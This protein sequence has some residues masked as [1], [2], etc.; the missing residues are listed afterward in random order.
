MTVL[1]AIIMGL[2]Q[3]LTEFL[4]VSSSAHLVFAD[5]FLHLH[6]DQAD[7]V[8]FDVLLHLGT[9]L[10]VL[11]YFRRDVLAL[12]RGAGQLLARP[13]QAW[14]ENPHAR[15][16]ALLVL[17]TIPAAL[18]GVL[19]KDFFSAA[20]QNV[21]GTAT[22]LLV[23][24]AMLFWITSRPV[25]GR[26]LDTANWK[27]ALLVG[28]FQAVAILPGVSRSGSTI[29]GGLVRGLDRDAA[30]RF[31]F[32]LSIPIILAGGLFDLKDTLKTGYHLPS[33]ALLAGFLTAAISGYIA[34]VLLMN[35][36]RRGRLNRFGYYC[37]AA[38]LLMLGYWTLLVPQIDAGKAAGLINQHTFSVNADGVL[39]P[40][41]MGQ[42]VQ[43]TLPVQAG[44][45]PLHDAYA[46]LP[47]VDGH[48]PQRISL[49]PIYTG[50]KGIVLL[51]SERYLLRPL[52][53]ESPTG[54][55]NIRNIWVVVRNRWGIQ[56]EVQLQLLIVPV[57]PQ[58]GTA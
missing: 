19:L 22:L 12:L 28:A 51:G 6:L 43:F 13:R 40:L 47:T 15:L 17:G 36:V 23:T 31:S 5:H 10:A 14:R 9:L 25:G 20:F 34:V 38:G 4:P 35:V 30:P 41:E 21:P 7:T 2:V 33:L 1:A 26:A 58:H 50:A 46:L 44:L 53:G 32:L 52:P 37:A 42:P 48:A 54:V 57:S 56:N 45:V 24:A 39:G 16:F 49:T 29:T 3:G 55:N 18:A 27:D 8:S 11:V